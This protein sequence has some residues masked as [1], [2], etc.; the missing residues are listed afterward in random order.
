LAT[1]GGYNN[2]PGEPPPGPK[3]IWLGLRRML[4]FSLA[5]LAFG[6]P[7]KNAQTCV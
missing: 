5:W 1:L 3:S 4:D 6:P 7:T 2:R